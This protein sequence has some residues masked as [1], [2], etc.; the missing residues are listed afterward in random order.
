MGKR[1]ERIEPA[2][3]E[4]ILAQ[5]IFFNASAAPEGRVNVSPRDAA[6]LRLPGDDS[7]VYLDVTGSGNETAAHLRVN[8]RL[9]LMFCSFSGAPMVLRLYGRG[10]IIA[11]GSS[12]YAVLLA[13][14]FSGVET[15]GARQMVWLDIE[16]VQT[17]C[18]YNVPLFDFVGE[19]ETLLRWAEKKGPEGLEQYWRE[20]N[21]VSI[22]GLPTGMFGAD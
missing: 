3:R 20:K 21:M 15:P 12:E 22:D 18:G 5:R 11:R 13:R 10:R 4:F 17:S 9:T 6:S 8:P 14:E 2:H 19:R 7:A 16:M 1:F